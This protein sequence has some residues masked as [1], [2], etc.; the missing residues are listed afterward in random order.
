MIFGD[1]YIIDEQ[2]V[3]YSVI[4]GRE[5]IAEGIRTVALRNSEQTFCE[6]LPDWSGKSDALAQAQVLPNY[7]H[8][9][10]LTLSMPGPV[11]R[12]CLTF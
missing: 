3:L 10:A 12:H 5:G 9:L 4:T 2:Q 11:A 1:T 6:I 7:N 8:H